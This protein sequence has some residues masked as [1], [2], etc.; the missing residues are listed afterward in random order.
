MAMDRRRGSG[1]S[2]NYLPLRDAIDRLFAESFISPSSG[3]SSF[4]PSDLYTTDNDVV[5]DMAIPGANPNDINVS[6]TGDSVTVSG[7]IRR[8]WSSGQQSGSGQSGSTQSSSSQ[9]AGQ[10]G[11]K[12]SS[13]HGAQPYFQEI[14]QGQFQRSFTLPI[15]VDSNKATANFDSGILTITM[16][17]SEATKPRKIQVQGQSNRVQGQSGQSQGTLQQEQVPVQSSGS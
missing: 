2:G 16:P 12:Q 14:W 9:G 13:G 11:G 10:T 1:A 5:L 3:F 6:V 17:K 15:E 7:H 8:E 4:P